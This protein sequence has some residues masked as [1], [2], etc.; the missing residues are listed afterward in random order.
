MGTLT[1]GVGLGDGGGGDLFGCGLLFDGLSG[2][3]FG[4]GFDASDVSETTATCLDFVG[5]LAHKNL[6]EKGLFW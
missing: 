5:L 3:G 1:Q 6:E 2:D 4:L